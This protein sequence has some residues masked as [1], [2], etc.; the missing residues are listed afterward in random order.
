MNSPI[1]LTSVDPSKK[2]QRFYELRREQDLFNQLVLVRTYG[3]I[4]KPG[5][6]LS[7][8]YADVPSLQKGSP[9]EREKIVR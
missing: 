6:V 1:R 9:H 3:R 7:R 2:R 8:V 5:R 4:G